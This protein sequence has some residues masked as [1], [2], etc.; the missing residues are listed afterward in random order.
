MT[1]VIYF[2]FMTDTGELYNALYNDSV[3]ID[4]PARKGYPSKKPI[5]IPLSTSKRPNPS[6]F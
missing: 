2:C 4:Q 1:R 3:K 6:Q 5:G